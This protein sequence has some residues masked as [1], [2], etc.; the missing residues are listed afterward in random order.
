MSHTIAAPPCIRSHRRPNATPSARA[1]AAA[2][3]ADRLAAAVE[4]EIARLRLIG[5]DTGDLPAI[6]RD[7]GELHGG[8]DELE[9]QLTAANR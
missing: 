6:A 7:L 9:Y 5:E 3:A 8:L 1:A 4:A 2:A